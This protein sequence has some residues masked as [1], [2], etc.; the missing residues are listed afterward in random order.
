MDFRLSGA[1]AAFQAEVAGFIA[2]G[3]PQGWDRDFASLAAGLEVERGVWRW[4]WT[5]SGRRL[6]PPRAPAGP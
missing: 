4:G 6:A 3:L 5:S 1:Q 2:G